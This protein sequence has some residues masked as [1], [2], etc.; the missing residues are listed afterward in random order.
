MRC[1]LPSLCVLLATVAGAHA[2][3]PALQ[4]DA[5]PV[6]LLALARTAVDACGDSPACKSASA[7][8]WI[9]RRRLGSPADLSAMAVQAEQGDEACLCG[10]V[11]PTTPEVER[12]ARLLAEASLLFHLAGEKAD[13]ARNLARLRNVGHK[14][15]ADAAVW[16]LLLRVSL[17][18]DGP[19]AALRDSG[20]AASPALRAHALTVAADSAAIAPDRR[21]A[22]L[23]YV[24]TEVS[25]SP[26]AH[27]GLAAPLAM[28]LHRVGLSA[29]ARSLLPLVPEASRERLASRLS[30]GDV[31]AKA[32]APAE[33][34]A[35]AT[36]LR[37]GRA[38]RD[39][40]A[41]L[42]A[43]A[44]DT[45]PYLWSAAG[46]EVARVAPREALEQTAAAIRSPLARATFAA[47]AAK[48]LTAANARAVYDE[49]L[50]TRAFPP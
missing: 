21:A 42:D 48:E 19:N 24:L 28:A 16:Q 22:V 20:S 11:T 50:F 3:A 17:L 13:A 45:A 33:A 29:D 9:L 10:K 4:P 43:L 25:Q 5:T 44:G 40:A 38:P 49:I 32:A 47:A 35:A 14:A 1:T 15:P 7:D 41:T 37:D 26:A 2:A 27:E 6:R 23:R 34:R 8:V 31:P 46:V 18:L 30:A 39:V 36:A 12:Q